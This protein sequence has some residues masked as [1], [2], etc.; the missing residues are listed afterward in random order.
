[1]T[2]DYPPAERL[3]VVDALPGHTIPDPYRY[4]EDP[5]DPRT[6]AWCA[7]QDRLAAES[8]EALPGRDAL[9]DSLTALLSAGTVSPPVWRGDRAFFTRRDPG[10]EHPV[11]IVDTPDGRRTLVDPNELDPE[12]LTALDTWSVSDEGDRVAYQVSVGGDE[13]SLLH[14]IDVATGELLEGPINRCRY[15]PVAWL[16]GGDEYFYVR[17]LDADVDTEADLPRRVLRHRVGTSPDTDPEIHGADNPPTTAYR[18]VTTSRDG[19]W[20]AIT[21]SR[22]TAP[23]DDMWLVD[24]AGDGVPSAVQVGVDAMAIPSFGPD[25]RLYIQTD[26]DAPRGR[27]CVTDPAAAD[28]PNWRDVVAESPDAVLEHS[29][30][31][32]TEPG[33]ADVAAV[34]ASHTRD[35]RSELSAYDPVTG[36][37]AGSVALPRAGTVI[38]MT[39]RPEGGRDCW[40]G[41]TDHA[42]PPAVLTWSADQPDRLATWA[43]AP[44]APDPAGL[45]VT[46]THYSSADGTDVHMFI[47]ADRAEPDRPV[48][49]ILYGYGGFNISLTPDYNPTALAWV[50]GGGAYAIANLRGGSERGEDWHRA[51]RRERKQNVFDDFIAA[52]EYLVERGWTTPGELAVSG[53]SNGGLLVGAA[54]TQRP[55]LV[56]AVL[57]S[58]PLLDMVRYEHAGLGRFWSDEYGTA[59][60]ED[61]LAWLFSYSPYHR[62]WS[63]VDYPA[64]LLTTFEGDTRVDPLHAR[65]MCAA[66][67]HATGGSG[68]VLLRR[69]LGVGHATRSVSRSAALISDQLA[70]V[71]A[72]LTAPGR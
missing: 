68:P 54:L 61:E 32:A 7:A 2:L 10:Q 12:G 14:V 48:P 46:E 45:V 25:N 13:R 70:F 24:L 60:R 22:G 37:R 53:G 67:Q 8:L 56:R 40:I 57:C 65:K 44:G 26:R 27:L 63:G 50:S 15:S 31:I 23:R 35:A 55:D 51:G 1:M 6:V 72:N 69:E 49:T 9:R 5:E 17:S 43:S 41:Y 39:T 34:L 66:L 33:S 30:L 11:L 18:V 29:A 62:V 38:E 28:Y 71:R 36:Q 16:P 19:R 58:K 42:T 64:V 47:L 20:L 21:S 4:L 59:T 3:D 52:G